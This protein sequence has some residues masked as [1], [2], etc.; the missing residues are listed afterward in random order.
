MFMNQSERQAKGNEIQLLSETVFFKK[1][2]FSVNFWCFI[3]G[4]D[5]PDASATACL[6][7]PTC[8]LKGHEGK[9]MLKFIYVKTVLLLNAY[10]YFLPL[11]H[12]SY[13]RLSLRKH[14]FLHV[15]R[16]W[17]RFARRNVC[18]SVTEIPYWWFKICPESGQK[19]WL[20]EGVVIL[21]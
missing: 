16:R 13:L 7:S 20:V 17:G 12:R 18:D 14:P 8:E 4:V 2:T 11:P 10:M 1:K 21:F 19:P 6:R 3:E 15:P 5:N 9:L